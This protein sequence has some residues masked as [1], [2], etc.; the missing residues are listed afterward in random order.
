MQSS[1][2]PADCRDLDCLPVSVAI[3]AISRSVLA[4]LNP[5]LPLLSCKDGARPKCTSAIL[6]A[7]DRIRGLRPAQTCSFLESQKGPGK[8]LV[9]P[10]LVSTSSQNIPVSAE[11]RVLSSPRLAIYHLL[12]EHRR[13]AFN[14]AVQLIAVMPGLKKYLEQLCNNGD[15]ALTLHRALVKQLDKLAVATAAKKGAM[16]DEFLAVLD[17]VDGLC[18]IAQ[19]SRQDLLCALYWTCHMFLSLGRKSSIH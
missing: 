5:I 11:L 14:S 8:L 17:K 13:C 1:D 15:D 10:A 6:R 7:G 19:R 2:I 12:G 16:L 9:L 4:E 18:N 3:F